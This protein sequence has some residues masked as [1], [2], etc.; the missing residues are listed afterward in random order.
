M[1]LLTQVVCNG[2]GV[3]LRGK[4]GQ[5]FEEKPHMSIRGRITLENL[6]DEAKHWHMFITKADDEETT[7]CDAKCFET[8][9]KVREQQYKKYREDKLR[10]EASSPTANMRQGFKVN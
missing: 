3:L 6:G 4:H 8:Y 2:C 10:A 9:C 7:V 5:R 1:A